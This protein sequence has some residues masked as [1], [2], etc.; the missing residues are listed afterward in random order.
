MILSFAW[1]GPDFIKGTKT[2][3]R[4]FY[5]KRQIRAWQRAWDEDRLIH[6]AWDKV[7]FAGGKRIGRFRLTKRPYLQPLNQ[8]TPLELLEEGPAVCRECKFDEGLFPSFVGK[9]P[10]AVALVIEFERIEESGSPSQTHASGTRGA[11]EGITTLGRGQTE[12]CTL[13]PTHSDTQ[14]PRT[15]CWRTCHL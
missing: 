4:R 14:Q 1:T 2:A 5:A 8:M 12:I 10:D 13:G 7:P 6:E 11:S 3:T 9:E 15:C